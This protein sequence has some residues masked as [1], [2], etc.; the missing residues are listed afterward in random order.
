MAEFTPIAP[1]YSI[2]S[3][4]GGQWHV[5]GWLHPFPHTFDPVVANAEKGQAQA[6]SVIHGQDPWYPSNPNG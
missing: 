1:P 3:K 2:Y 6:W 4:D 5:I